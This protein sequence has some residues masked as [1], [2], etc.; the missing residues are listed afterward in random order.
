MVGN[1]STLASMLQGRK[2][3][4]KEKLDSMQVLIFVFQ[5]QFEYTTAFCQYSTHDFTLGCV[6][7]DET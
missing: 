7:D 3:Q 6:G 5:T 1:M 2:G 4:L